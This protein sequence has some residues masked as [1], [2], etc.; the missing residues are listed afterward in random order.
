MTSAERALQERMASQYDSYDDA[1]E[2]MFEADNADA[3]MI[4]PA[5]GKRL[6]SAIGRSKEQPVF[7]AQFDMSI[8]PLLY[9]VTIATGAFVKIASAAL[10]A[11]LKT[12][13]P[14]VLFGWADY[15]S[16]FAYGRQK[17]PLTGG[18]AYKDVFTYGKDEPSTIADLAATYNVPF[19]AAVSSQLQI[20]DVVIALEYVSGGATDNYAFVVHRCQNVA[21][22]SLLESLASDRFGI[23]QIRYNIPDTTKVA[24]FSNKLVLLRQSLFGRDTADSINPSAFKKPEQFQNGIVDIGLKKGIDKETSIGTYVNYDVEQI[25]L[26]IYVWKTK[27]LLA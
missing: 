16:G 1:F 22:G 12:K 20:G 26:S 3:P 23:N 4:A 13:V 15:A 10:P 21:Y 5:Q 7:A 18:W 9:D 8:L 25:D 17:L 6:G 27:K 19:P 24:Q 11:T 2:S 14:A